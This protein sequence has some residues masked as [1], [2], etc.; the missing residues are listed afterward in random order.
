VLSVLYFLFFLA[1][2]IYPNIDRTKQVPDRVTT[3]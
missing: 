1:M 3:K 2:P